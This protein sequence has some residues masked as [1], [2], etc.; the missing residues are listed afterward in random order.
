M[1]DYYVVK[2]QVNKDPWDV[3]PKLWLTRNNGDDDDESDD[4]DDYDQCWW[5]N[6]YQWY[7]KSNQIIFN[8]STKGWKLCDIVEVDNFQYGSLEEA[9]V[10]ADTLN[11][12]DLEDKRFNELKEQV[13]IM[14]NKNRIIDC[15]CNCNSYVI[16][17][18]LNEILSHS[19]KIKAMLVKIKQQAD[20]KI[21]KPTLEK[22]LPI[23]SYKDLKT[24]ETKF[25][26]EDWISPALKELIGI[27]TDGEKIHESVFRIL[28]TIFSRELAAQCTWDGNNGLKIK[29]LLVIKKI[30]VTLRGIAPEYNGLF[31]QDVITWFEKNRNSTLLPD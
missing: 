24:F 1:S 6:N 22:L 13:A 27:L 17:K 19:E 26:E 3:A 28:E 18:K 4:D 9:E 2:F 31:Q 21:V 25:L 20:A 12:R 15:N 30:E 23:K 7:K 10:R 8:G 29:D 5:P 14:G 11:R 16:P